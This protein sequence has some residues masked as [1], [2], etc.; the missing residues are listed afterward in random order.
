MITPEVSN[1]S[2][3]RRLS[4]RRSMQ[5]GVDS[6]QVHRVWTK[7]NAIAVG[8]G[9]LATVISWPVVQLAPTVGL[10]EGWRFGLAS[11]AV[12]HIAWGPDLDFTYG[13]LGFLT[14]RTLYF[15][16]TAALAL[17]YEFAIPFALFALLFRFTRTALPLPIAAVASYA[18]GATA[19]ILPLNGDGGDLLMGPTILL[20]ILAVR[21]REQ[22]VRRCLIAI[23]SAVSALGVLIKFTDGL[24]PFGIVVVIIAVGWGRRRLMETAIAALTFLSVLVVSWVATGNALGDLPAYFHY[25]AAIAGGYSSAMQLEIGSADEW[26]YAA[27]ALLVLAALATLSLRSKPRREQLGTAL[28][29]LGFTWWAIKEGFVRHAGI[30]DVIFFSMM[31]VAMAAFGPP[32]RLRAYYITTVAFIGIIVWSAAGGIPANMLAWSADVHSFGH[33]VDILIDSKL[34]TSTIDE[35]RREMRNTYALT[36]K[37]VSELGGHTVAIEPWENSVAWAY[38]SIHWDPEPVLQAFAAYTSTLDTLDSHFIQSSAAPSRILEQRPAAIDG[39]NPS[40]DPPTTVVSVVCH[41][42]QLDVSERWQVLTRV[43]D[44]C[45]APKLLAR[46]TATFG[47]AVKVPVGPPGTMVVARFQS[48]PLSIGYR[49]SAILLK[50]PI[51]YLTASGR[52]YRFLPGTAGDLHLL[53]GTPSMGY[54]TQF[55]PTNIPHFHLSGAGVSPGSGHYVVNFYSMSV[56]SA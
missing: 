19:M 56:A 52:P 34:R 33:Q 40:F 28:I 23:L 39:R 22:W 43:P 41:Y 49:I 46:R 26:W 17:A 7:P 1:S 10:D 9:L 53:R 6:A 21:Q 13:P 29:L 38:P 2:Q 48:L 32:P 42:V 55:I 18:I 36:P 14:V 15:G 35:A 3:P 8:F 50:P 51:V 12:H 27:I 54:A 45:G 37:M 20:A 24:V 31:F 5:R 44:R 16:P 25:T 11:A 4:L 30:Q 47:Q